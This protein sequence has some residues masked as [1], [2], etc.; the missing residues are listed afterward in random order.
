MLVRTWNLFH[1]NTV[2]P[3]RAARLEEAVGL[4]SADRPDVLCLQEVPLWALDRLAAW[5][6]LAAFGEPAARASV[7]PFPA[8]PSLGRAL[9]RLH[10]GLFRSA[11]AGQANAILVRPE[12]R[13]EAAGCIVLNP[14]RFRRAQAHWLAL[15]PVAR[16]A[17]AGE[18]RVCHAV[19]LALPD[20]RTALVANLH[21]TAYRPDARLADAELLRAAVFAD[22]V[23]R[24]DEVCVLAGDFNARTATSW[25]L[26]E[27]AKP[28]WGF[29]GGGRGIDHVLARGADVGPVTTWPAARRRR[30][31]LLLSDHA[32]VEAVVG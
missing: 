13:P 9:T 3:R 27:L 22:T 17:W 2:P 14:R 28:D 24:P 11:F 25:T 5:S 18:R 31:G 8:T 16:L 29:R 30:N 32:P 1:G 6:G 12:H 20:G 23:A 7:G 15:S 4:A 26:R 10:H 21:A 19:R